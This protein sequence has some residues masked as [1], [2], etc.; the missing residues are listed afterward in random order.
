MTTS[1]YLS[2][3]NGLP[4]LYNAVSV[5]SGV[6]DTGK[7]P[8]LDSTGKVDQ[9]MLSLLPSPIVTVSATSK[10]LALSDV[11]SFQMCTATTAV[12]ITVPPNSSVAFPVGTEIHI[13]QDNVGAVTI[14]AG[15]GVTIVTYG[16]NAAASYKVLGRYATVTLKKLSTNGWL[17]TGL[18]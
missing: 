16:L 4:T 8:A 10:T 5:S 13:Y 15:S 12:S 7:I 11:S 3:L 14:F 6:S 1:K 18:V 2:I 17:L 9:S